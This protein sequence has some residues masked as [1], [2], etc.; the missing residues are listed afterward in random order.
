MIQQRQSLIDYL[1]ERFP[2]HYPP[3]TC[4]PGEV[5]DFQAREHPGREF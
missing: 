3:R 2:A 1:Q 5:E 4:S